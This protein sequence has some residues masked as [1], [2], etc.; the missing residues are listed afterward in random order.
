MRKH[1]APLSD[2]QK[3]KRSRKSLSKSL[4]V[5]I[6]RRDGWLCYWCKRPVI[7]SPAMKLLD[8][9]VRNAVYGV[10]PAYY[11]PHGTREGAPLLDELGAAID[12]IEAFSTGGAC[13]RENLRTSCWKCN[14]RKSD[15]SVAKWEERSKRSAI[16]GKYGEPKDW[17]GLASVFT[18]L[19]ERNPARLTSGEREWLKA[20]KASYSQSPRSVA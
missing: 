9:E 5:A 4:Q 8:A 1:E 15:A 12:H 13:S 17:D 3:A 10:R 11:H 7:F 2:P 18:M 19:A 16:K 6:F 20:I 14:V